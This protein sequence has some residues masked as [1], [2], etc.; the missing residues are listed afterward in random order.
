MKIYG[1]G[2]NIQE[3]TPADWFTNK[4]EFLATLAQMSVVGDEVNHHSRDMM[5]RYNSFCLIK[6][7]LK[8]KVLGEVL[9]LSSAINPRDKGPDLYPGVRFTECEYRR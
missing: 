5:L 4:V 7:C 2:D 3:F 9:K 6:A 8:S 1:W